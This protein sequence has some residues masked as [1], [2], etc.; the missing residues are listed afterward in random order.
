[1]D[2]NQQKVFSLEK[3]KITIVRAKSWPLLCKRGQ[4]SFIRILI[5]NSAWNVLWISLNHEMRHVS[6]SKWTWRWPHPLL[7]FLLSTWVNL[8]RIVTCVQYNQENLNKEQ[9]SSAKGQIS[10]HCAVSTINSVDFD[11][12]YVNILPWTFCYCKIVTRSSQGDKEP[13]SHWK[14]LDL[15]AHKFDNRGFTCLQSCKYESFSLFT[16]TPWFPR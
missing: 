10:T 12:R 1:M 7:T 14:A 9:T 6:Q 3:K 11:F 8:K 15:S 16:P 5:N 2:P 4:V 13:R